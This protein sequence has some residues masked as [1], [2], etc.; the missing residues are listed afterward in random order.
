MEEKTLK[1]ITLK[2]LRARLDDQPYDL[3]NCL[4][5]GVT[6][7]NSDLEGTDFRGAVLRGC[8]ISHCKFDN[9]HFEGADLGD[10]RFVRCKMEYCT[11]YGAEMGSVTFDRCALM[12]ST[13]I[14]GDTRMQS[15]VDFD[16]SMGFVRGIDPGFLKDW[17]Q[18]AWDVCYPDEDA[19][20]KML[21]EL[22]EKFDEIDRAYPGMGA[23]I[24][25]SCA[26]FLP[27][28]LRGAANFIAC[29]NT[30]EAARQLAIQGDFIG[31]EP[32]P[33][34][35]V[36]VLP[37]SDVQKNLLA[38]RAFTAR[39]QRIQG[40][41]FFFSKS[42]CDLARDLSEVADG[43][44]DHEDYRQLLRQ[45][46]DAFEQI[47]QSYPGVAAAMFSCEAGYLPGEMLSAAKW[48]SGGGS[49]K[50]AV[51]MARAGAFEQILAL[52][53]GYKTIDLIASYEDTFAVPYA[54]RLTR[55]WGD[56]G[57]HVRKDGVTDEQLREVYV[58]ALGVLGIGSDTFQ[59]W[60]YGG[61]G[62]VVLRLRSSLLAKSLFPGDEIL[63]IPL[64]PTGPEGQ[65]QYETGRVTEINAAV[66]SC[67]VEVEGGEMTVPLRYVLARF[68]GGLPGNAF[69]YEHAQPLYYLP[70]AWAGDLLCEAEEV[71]E[72]QLAFE[73]EGDPGQEFGGMTMK[74]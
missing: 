73:M 6:L 70:E 69:G 25:N 45:Y 27:H 26:R 4:L 42:W 67:A 7:T 52:P 51:E 48:I 28:E 55:Y 38:E 47:E 17:R 3:S 72:A 10:T 14:N 15:E 23:E 9:S 16:G 50:K 8:T 53:P 40:L 65:F 63:F 46:G 59:S 2:E 54:E 61:R 32:L 37:H 36:F 24:F 31:D 20:G 68:D 29:G 74:M 12:G 58:K 57:G 60:L 62:D 1:P 34:H 41:N 21:W 33:D 30:P 43:V 5:V 39:M 64:C 56:Y 22:Q 18:F 66:K 49:P 11:F 44:Y 71:N 13:G 35:E 19:Y